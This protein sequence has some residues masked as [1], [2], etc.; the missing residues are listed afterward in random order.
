MTPGRRKL[1]LIGTVLFAAQSYSQNMPTVVNMAKEADW[2]NLEYLLEDGLNPNVI[3]GDGTT[4]LHW[5]SYHDSLSG[6]MSLLE[7][8]A[9]VNATTDLGVTPLWL[10]AENSS[11]SITKALLEAGADPSI[12]L[13]SGETIVMTAAQS[14]NGDV[15]KALLAA[16]ADPNAAVTRG[17]TALMW[18]AGRGYSDAIE[19]LLEYGAN[20]HARSVVRP[21]YVKSE[22]V[23]DSHPAYKYWIEQGGNTAL[24]FAARSGDRRSA[25][26]LVEAGSDVND[27]SAFGTSP[28]MMA[29]HGGNSE[30]LDYLLENGADPDLNRRGQTALHV[31]GVRGNPQAVKVFIK[32]GADLEAVLESPTPT[33]RQST[34]YS[35]HD[36][37]IGA[38]PLWLAARF[39]EPLIMESLIQ[40]GADPMVVID[41]SYPAQ[42][43]GELYTANEG[44]INLVMAA[45]GLGHPRLRVSW[46]TPERRAGQLQDRQSLVLD[47]VRVAV[48]AGADI[49]AR[50]M[51]GQSALAFAKQR[52]YASVVAFLDATGAIE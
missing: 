44:Q 36:A 40:A 39:S 26:L 32:H 35:F 52:R 4:A 21:Q 45:V 51:E 37:L 9:D 16:G 1:L 41:I 49:N 15:V 28:A 3:Y 38:T 50:N 33:R 6:T 12:S 13:L 29:V 27:L 22:K 8:G 7:A 30:L 20:V 46:G 2:E 17:Q 19:A 10:A 43:L 24:M 23:Q 11:V 5:A 48:S 47:S 18:A 42:R 31:A 34:D 14:G 25:Q